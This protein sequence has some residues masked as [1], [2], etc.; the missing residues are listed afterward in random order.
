MKRVRKS[1]V[2]IMT[3]QLDEAELKQALERLG[4]ATHFDRKAT[5]EIYLNLAVICGT[6]L[7]E[8]ETK[9]SSPIAKALRSLGCN[10]EEA[11]HLLGGNRTG[12]QSTIETVVTGEAIRLLALDPTVGSVESARTLVEQFCEQSAKIAHS[13]M[14]AH[15][16]LSEKSTRDGRPILAWYNEFTKLLLDIAGKSSVKP[17]LGKDP[18]TGARIGWLY[19]AAEALEPFL[20]PWMRSLSAAARAKR[21]ERS[22]KR[23]RV[24]GPTKVPRA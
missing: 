12:I 15:A 21:L 13:C 4:V 10:L 11:S 5:D 2:S 8:Q 9:D 14:V 6:W 24:K 19:E 23:L 1:G 3:P 18:I 17:T 16:E 7:D 22:L 20:D